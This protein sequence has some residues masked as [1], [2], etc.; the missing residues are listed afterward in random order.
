MSVFSAW[1]STLG[2]W[3]L[4]AAGEFF[5]QWSKTLFVG[6]SGYCFGDF[7]QYPSEHFWVATCSAYEH[8]AEDDLLPILDG[9]FLATKAGDLLFEFCD[10]L[11]WGLGSHRESI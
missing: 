6:V 5:Q 1:G 2:S 9:S 11:L 4:E 8:P 10:L 3:A 7:C